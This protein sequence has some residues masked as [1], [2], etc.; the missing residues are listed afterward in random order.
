[1][2]TIRILLFALLSLATA[3]AQTAEWIWHTAKAADGEV[4]FFRKT[5]TVPAG[6]TEATLLVSG[7]NHATAYLNG[8]EVAK[9]DA[10]AEPAKARVEKQ[11]RPGENV[12]AIRGKNDDG[13]AAVVAR[14]EAKVGGVKQVLVVTDTTWLSGEKESAGWSAAEF[15][16]EGWGK[17][18][19][20]A[21]LGAAPWG[22]VFAGAKRGGSGAAADPE[23]G[24]AHV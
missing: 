4:R 12:L 20:I 13:V 3:R 19:T 1:M 21:K 22:D 10:W 14:I 16:A 24:R 7:D 23:I 6:V 8:A 18:V 11:L 5:F 9:T 17:P 2:H 15:K